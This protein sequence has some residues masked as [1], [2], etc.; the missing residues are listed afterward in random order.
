MDEMTDGRDVDGYY[1]RLDRARNALLEQLDGLPLREPER[2]VWAHMLRIGDTVLLEVLAE[3]I[4]QAR[5]ER[6]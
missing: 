2:V 6:R 4:R 3:S 5:E 1:F